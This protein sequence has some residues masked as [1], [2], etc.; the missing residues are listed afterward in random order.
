M[1]RIY[2]RATGEQVDLK[3]RVLNAAVKQS[4]EIANSTTLFQRIGMILMN[5]IN[6]RA[7][8]KHL[9]CPCPCVSGISTLPFVS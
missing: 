3:V 1:S 9:S 7:L 5:P 8:S 2:A 4:V 6:R